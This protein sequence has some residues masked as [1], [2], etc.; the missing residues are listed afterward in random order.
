LTTIG[1]KIEYALRIRFGSDL[2]LLPDMPDIIPLIFG[3]VCSRS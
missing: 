2:S 3:V 1:G